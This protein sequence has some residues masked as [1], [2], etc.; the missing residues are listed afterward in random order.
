MGLDGVIVSC[1]VWELALGRAISS[2][3]VSSSFRLSLVLARFSLKVWRERF[4]K[5]SF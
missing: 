4:G 5:R 1:P 3:F 2:V